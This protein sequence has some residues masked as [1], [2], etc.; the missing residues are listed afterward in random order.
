VARS[1]CSGVQREVRH[2]PPE[3]RHRLALLALE[4]AR[5]PGALQLHQRAGIGLAAR[6]PRAVRAEPAFGAAQGRAR[7]VEV[8]LCLVEVT[9]R[10]H[11]VRL[12][13]V[14]PAE[15]H[16]KV[17]TRQLAFRC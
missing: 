13:A 5:L 16:G 12:R 7:P 6:E 11:E 17:L 10:P 1:V 14:Q 2:A 8:P 9:L 3:E 4:P 15:H